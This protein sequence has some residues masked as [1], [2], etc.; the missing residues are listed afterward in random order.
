MVCAFSPSIYSFRVCLLAPVSLPPLSLITVAFR[1]VVRWVSVPTLSLLLL[2]GSL[3]FPSFLLSCFL[4]VSSFPALSFS[5]SLPSSIVLSSF[6]IARFLS[7]SL[8]ISLILSHS[9]AFALSF[10]LSM[11]FSL[12]PSRCHSCS[13]SLSFSFC[14]PLARLLN[15]WF[16]FMGLHSLG[17]GGG[18][19]IAWVGVLIF[20]SRWCYHLFFVG[21]G[22]SFLPS[23]V[24]LPLGCASPMRN[25]G[26]CPLLPDFSSSSQGLAHPLLRVS[27]FLTLPIP[28]RFSLLRLPSQV[29]FSPSFSLWG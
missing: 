23:C 7:L 8:S 3:S 9:L 29:A 13:L 27:R 15:Q 10:S 17:G 11:S 22:L 4:S 12:F 25:V 2:P 28:L 20:A 14:L 24:H 18:R 16:L 5:L 6:S 21:G 19:V 1:L 26:P